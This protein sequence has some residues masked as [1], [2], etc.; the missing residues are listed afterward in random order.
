MLI[1]LGLIVL[2]MLV[3]VGLSKPSNF[4][5]W[6]GSNPLE[7]SAQV[8][9]IE[10]L[11]HTTKSFDILTGYCVHC[12]WHNPYE[13]KVMEFVSDIVVDAEPKCKIG[14]MIVVYLSTK[15]LGKYFVCLK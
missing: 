15:D 3:G 9:A 4:P 12:Q 11:T 5:A 10:K 6:L 2:A 13:D 8:T 1:L 14:D 7:V